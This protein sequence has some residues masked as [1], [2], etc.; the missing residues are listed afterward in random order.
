M[1]VDTDELKEL[2]KALHQGDV[3]DIAKTVRLYSPDAP[4]WPDEVADIPH[5]EP[6]MTMETR[7]QSRLSVIVTQDCDL[8]REI[9]VEPYVI[10]A[11]LT[12][13]DS[14]RYAQA[15]N[16]QSTRFFAYPPIE[17]HEDK[18]NLVIDMRVLSS[19]EKTALLSSHIQRIDCPLGAPDRER[20]RE[21]VGDRFGRAPL[22]DDIVRQAV[23]P[24]EQALKRITEN[25]TAAAVLAATI[26]YGLQRTPG[27][28]YV[29]LMLLTD[30]ARRE[31]F[32]VGEQE[33]A[34]AVNRLRKALAHFARNSDYSIVANVHDATEISA[35]DM[36]THEPLAL[37]LD[38]V[39]LELIAERD[40]KERTKAVPEQ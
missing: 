39:D 17:G 23:T 5:E 19:L 29:S 26:F 40:A 37:D 38:L 35:A 28:Q 34:G 1:S 16:R 3:V 33:L 21:V 4:T 20:L 12:E 31:R 15:A 10:L 25:S 14:S 32:K 24:I 7:H 27:R 6:V 13:V 11:P 22:P 18:Q 8:R 2:L 9:T 36:L 30:P